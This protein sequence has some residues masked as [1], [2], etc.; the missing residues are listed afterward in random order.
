MKNKLKQGLQSAY[1]FLCS[2]KSKAMLI[3]VIGCSLVLFL[4]YWFSPF[5]YISLFFLCAII[6]FE[7]NEKSLLYSLFIIG[8]VGSDYAYSGNYVIFNIS[9][10]GFDIHFSMLL[11]AFMV[12]YYLSRYFFAVYKREKKLMIVP[13]L[14]VGALGLLLLIPY[15]ITTF[16]SVANFIVHLLLV[17]VFVIYRKSFGIRDLT[18]FVSFGVIWFTLIGFVLYKLGMPY[19]VSYFEDGVLKFQGLMGNPNSLAKV[20]LVAVVLVMYSFIKKKISFVEFLPLFTLLVI[21]G[22]TTISRAWTML[23]ILSF[24]GF[25][26]FYI[27]TYKKKSIMPV[28]CVCLCVIVAGII[29]LPYTERSVFR[30]GEN[31]QTSDFTVQPPPDPPPIDPQ[32]TD[33]PPET[34]I[35]DPGRIGI[36]KFCIEDWLES[37]KTILLGHGYKAEPTDF[38]GEHGLPFFMLRRIGIIGFALYLAFL[39]SLF[40]YVNGRSWKIKLDF[41]LIIFVVFGL[42]L[43]IDIPLNGIM[44]QMY[45]VLLVTMSDKSDKTNEITTADSEKTLAR[46]VREFFRKKSAYNKYYPAEEIIDK[47]SSFPEPRDIFE[48]A[49]FQNAC[50][51]IAGGKLLRFCQNIYGRIKFKRNIKIYKNNFCESKEKKREEMVFWPHF[52]VNLSIMPQELKEKY[53]IAYCPTNVV[54][55]LNESDVEYIEVL[56]K[57]FK[58]SWWFLNK[59]VEYI[60][61]IRSIMCTYNVK[62]IITINER[63]PCACIVTDFCRK[64]EIKTI[65]IQH[66]LHFV[67]LCSAFYECDEMYVWD[68]FTKDLHVAERCKANIIVAKDVPATTFDFSNLNLQTK[69]VID[70]KFY[71][72][73]TSKK[74]L[75]N[76]KNI[77]EALKISGKSV[78]VRPHPRSTY[79]PD[80][81]KYFSENDI[82]IPSSCDIVQSVYSAKNIVSIDSTVL[83]QAYNSGKNIILDDLSNKKRFDKL[84]LVGNILIQIEHKLLS[85]EK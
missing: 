63:I 12:L 16:E 78:L 75:R 19:G 54:K 4:G 72:T 44:A 13:F 10:F 82:E 22:L 79:L 68:D 85:E 41:S 55:M 53:D 1:S 62:Q 17:L 64:H 57:E 14:I 49:H 7:R 36:W 67:D 34:R 66:G 30:I 37:P 15:G 26:V 48:R 56:K 84:K 42:N 60:G 83:Y 50:H 80:V 5:V 46:K 40:Y 31:W 58:R 18:I 59:A 21:I 74:E 70:Y 24:I 39:A 20:A 23:F 33:P 29:C 61:A 27:L 3:K 35:W 32:P 69:D 52:D 76:L 77:V 6:L 9:I 51:L 25:I 11:F 47:I 8:M 43:F 81:R 73:L 28:I 2:T 65:N 71:L 38:T 45:V